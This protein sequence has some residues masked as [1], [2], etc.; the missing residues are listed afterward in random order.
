MR[1][2]IEPPHQKQNNIPQSERYQAY[3]YTKGY[4]THRSRCVRCGKSHSTEKCT[5]AKT[6]P[7]E[8]LHCGESHPARYR[9]CEVYQEIIRPSFAS[10]RPIPSIHSTN[11][12]RQ[13]NE[14]S[15]APEKTEGRSEIKYAQATRNSIT[16]SKISANNTQGNVFIK[17][18]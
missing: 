6:Q 5:A 3:F 10:P 18:I 16:T 15:A 9:G 4:C 11:I 1:V 8:Y 17:L 7:E 13:E 2:Q 12:A 14:S